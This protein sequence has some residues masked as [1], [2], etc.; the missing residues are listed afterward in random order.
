MVHI[1]YL[2][3]S[4]IQMST[5]TRNVLKIIGVN[6]AFDIV[7]FD[8]RNLRGVRN[9]GRKTEVEVEY[10]Q[11]RLRVIDQLVKQIIY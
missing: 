8:I 11:K 1:K 9:S 10:L 4:D 5:R 7:H 2:T 6:T 3:I